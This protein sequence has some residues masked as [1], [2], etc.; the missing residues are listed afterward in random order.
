MHVS[1]DAALD[2]PDVALDPFDRPPR[3]VFNLVVYE[4]PTEP[5]RTLLKMTV[6]SHDDRGPLTHEVTT[7]AQTDTAIS[8]LEQAAVA[9]RRWR[10]F[11]PQ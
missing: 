9:L 10:T 6:T 8:E 3:T 11:L 5:R 7:R 1:P 4:S 2:S